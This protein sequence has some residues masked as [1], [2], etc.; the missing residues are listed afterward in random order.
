MAETATA[1]P[2]RPATQPPPTAAPAKPAD[3]KEEWKFKAKNPSLKFTVDHLLTE[4]CVELTL[5]LSP[6]ISATFRTMGVDQVQDV[7]RAV[8][9]Q[10]KERSYKY[11]MN[12]LS[13]TQIYHSLVDVNGKLLPP[14][15]PK[16]GTP[17]YD[18]TKDP[19]MMMVR[20]YPVA[21][22]DLL[23]KGLNEF[24]ARARALVGGDSLAN[25]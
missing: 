17:E 7:E 21:L 3:P 22:F 20:N 23:L 19:R 1:T 15:S 2:A 16:K 11:T 13:I 6:Q 5:I 9:V 18:P 4:N 24:D 10:D 12:E 25:F 8:N 14:Y